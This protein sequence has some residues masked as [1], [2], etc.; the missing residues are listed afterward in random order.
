M[1]PKHRAFMGPP[2][3]CPSASGAPVSFYLGKLLLQQNSVHDSRKA[4]LRGWAAGHLGGLM[5]TRAAF[6]PRRTRRQ[7]QPCSQ[8]PVSI[9]PKRDAGFPEVCLSLSSDAP[10]PTLPSPKTFLVFP[11]DP[12][13]K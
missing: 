8:L 4:G 6:P 10:G 11:S 9:V 3:P 12:P 13:Q 7:R 5:L 1:A 2:P